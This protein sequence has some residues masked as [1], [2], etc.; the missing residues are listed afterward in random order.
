MPLLAPEPTYNVSRSAADIRDWI[1]QELAASLKTV[2]ESIDTAAELQTLGVDSLAAIGMTGALSGWLNRDLPSTLMW[3]YP[4]I[5]A[6]CAGLAAPQESEKT[7]GWPGVMVF[8]GQ[9]DQTPLFCFPGLGG[10]PVTFAPLAGLLG[11]RQPCYGL[12]APGLMGE[13]D[14]LSRI[15][16]ISSAM[17]ANLRRV[18]PRGPYQLAGYSLGGMFAFEAAQQLVAAG[19]RVSLLAIF[20]GYTADGKV[21]RRRWERM[22]L[23]AWIV[24]TAPDR[25]D[26]L[27]SRREKWR[28]R[29]AQGEQN[30]IAA[31]T[32]AQ[33]QDV[34]TRATAAARAR[35]R[36]A[37]DYRPR[38]YPGAILMFRPTEVPVYDRFYKIDGTGGWGKHSRGGIEVFDLPGSHQTMLDAHHAPAAA[39]IL[40]RNLLVSPP[41]GH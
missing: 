26:Y 21:Q 10:H 31:T 32:S 7:P 17:L 25:M 22:A 14:P 12:T 19:E 29:Q 24:A 8:Q 41:A 39:A 38:S 6:L 18:Q 4:T 23:H 5:D 9:G 35:L 2:P 11:P 30:E 34:L 16:D 3:D 27:R 1:V 37:G 36:A 13:G 33:T 40:K 28:S 15:E 20:N